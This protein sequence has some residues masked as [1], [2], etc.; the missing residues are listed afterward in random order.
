MGDN[1]REK[2]ANIDQKRYIQ[3]LLEFEG[4]TSCHATILP[5]KASSILVLD[6][7]EDH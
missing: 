2:Y 5:I 3:N 6:Q 1:P 4:M 7:V